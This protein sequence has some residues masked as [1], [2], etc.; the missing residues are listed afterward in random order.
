LSTAARRKIDIKTAVESLS[1]G[2]VL[3][4]PTETV[5][6][7]GADIKFPQAIESIFDMKG[8]SESKAVSLLVSGVEMAKTISDFDA[9][10]E[11]L[12][13][14]FWPGPVTFVLPAK[15]SV[16][17]AV[18]GGSGFV[19]MRCSNHPFV[20]ALMA[21]YPR[22]VTTTSAN[23]AGEKPAQSLVELAWLPEA[24]VKVPWT[25][26]AEAGAPSTVMR[27]DGRNIEVLREGGIPSA[28]V[29]RVAELL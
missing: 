23:R 14:T 13:H 12:L 20:A 27:I 2:K 3:A 28:L 25:V 21:E 11:R 24:V 4:Y 8:R 5:W 18:H 29:R 19:G 10:V 15:T 9:R 16:P 6:G 22:P 26:R 1:G 17:E 7:L